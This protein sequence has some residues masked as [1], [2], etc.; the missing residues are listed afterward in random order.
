[1]SNKVGQFRGVILSEFGRCAAA[2]RQ[3]CD[4]MEVTLLAQEFVNEGFVDAKKF[5]DLTLAFVLA[6]NGIKDSLSKV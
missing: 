1:M 2:V 4:V 5:G 3:G 6:L